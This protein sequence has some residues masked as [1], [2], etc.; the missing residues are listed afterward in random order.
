MEIEKVIEHKKNNKS[1]KGFKSAKE[2]TNQEILELDCDVLIPAALED[3]I[4][5]ENADNI[6]AKIVLELANHPVTAEADTTLE[7]KRI[8]VVPDIL[9]SAGGV[10]VSY[11]EWVQNSM[12]YYWTKEEV[13]KKLEEHM[14]SATKEV[15]K[16]CKDVKCSMRAASYILAVNKVLQAERLRGVLT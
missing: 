4:T 14:I 7:K 11:F 3:Q 8:A 2:I 16:T 6:K 15:S 9:A 1:L 13:L 12:N 10:V 5:K